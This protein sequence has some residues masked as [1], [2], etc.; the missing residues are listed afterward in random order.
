M[1]VSSIGQQNELSLSM[2]AVDEAKSP[3]RCGLCLGAFEQKHGHMAKTIKKSEK[4]LETRMFGCLD[5][6]MFGRL[7]Y[8]LFVMVDHHHL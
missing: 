1:L 8:L 2:N 5:V 4:R 7:P 6:W 3:I